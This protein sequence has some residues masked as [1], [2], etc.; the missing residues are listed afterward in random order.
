MTAQ[1]IASLL[2]YII[3]GLFVIAVMMFVLALQQLRRGRRGPYWRLRRQASQ[4]G[5]VLFL[6]SVGLFTLAVMLAF[7]S[8][9]A[10]VAYRGVD[11]FFRA[12]QSG[13]VG[14]VVPTETP[15]LDVTE[16]LTP[17][18]T[19][20][21]TSTSVPTATVQPSDTP[22][23]TSTPTL[24][25]TATPTLTLTPTV[26][27][28]PT[29]T[30]TP[31]ATVDSVLNLTPPAT[32]IAARA[33]ASFQLTAADVAVSLDNRPV[34]ARTM[35]PAGIQRIYLF[36]SYQD[37]DQG[38]VWSRVLYRDGHPVQG[39]AYLWSQPEDGES[40]FFFGNQDG[41]PPGEYEARLYIGDTER[42]RFAFSV[43]P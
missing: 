22:A 42:S 1:Q 26:T 3:V 31:T 38:V 20:S 12:R 9:L 16:T 30:F 29:A 27:A 19:A 5:G 21:P 15:T 39:Q 4:R 37:M 13:L 10:A 41:Y 17:E 23:P 36:F 33:S 18:P 32:G 24:T 6:A 8:G 40:Y 34:E 2:T 14:V 25:S 35:F 28:T 11:D 43:M 7:Y